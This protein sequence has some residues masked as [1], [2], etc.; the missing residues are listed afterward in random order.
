MGAA[1]LA[2]VA[3]FMPSQPKR[4][5]IRRRNPIA[6]RTAIAEN[7]AAGMK[8]ERSP[9]RCHASLRQPHIPQ[10]RNPRHLG[11]GQDRSPWLTIVGVVGDEKRATVYKENPQP[12]NDKPGPLVRIEPRSCGSFPAY[13]SSVAQGAIAKNKKLLG[14]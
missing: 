5:A 7:V 3:Q 4:S 2:K 13:I 6:P 9:A 14:S 11:R 1:I 12:R 10:R 8:S